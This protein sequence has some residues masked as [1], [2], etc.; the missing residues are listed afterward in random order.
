MAQKTGLLV[1]HLL[2]KCKQIEMRSSHTSGAAASK[3]DPVIQQLKNPVKMV[4]S[5]VNV[6][7]FFYTWTSQHF[8]L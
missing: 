3:N 2:A 4:T 6:S 1:E 8:L 7:I 5:A